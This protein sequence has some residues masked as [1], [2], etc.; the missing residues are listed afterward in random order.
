VINRKGYDGAKADIWACGVILYV[1]LAGYLP[2]QEKT[3]MGMYKKICRAEL[4]WPSW[5]SSD[6][7]KLLRRILHPNPS[8]RISIAE[9]MENPW[10]RTGLDARLFNGNI[11]PV[12]GVVSANMDLTLNSLNVTTV[13]EE[14]EAEKL[15]NL[16]AFDIISLSRGFDLSGIFEENSSKEESKFTSNNTASTIITKLEDIAKSLRLKLTNKD[17]GLL[18]MEGSKPGRKGVMSVDAEIFQI[19]PLFHLV[20]IK[21]TNG[22]TLE[23]NKVMEQDMRSA[24]KGMS[25][26]GKVSNPT[27]ESTTLDLVN[28]QVQQ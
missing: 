18:K 22:D 8:A 10:F 23:Y 19:T 17:G 4:K 9:I 6:V 26:P 3:L 15:T 21:K 1:L 7:R 14:Q 11:N 28:K 24:L 16:N 27:A 5:F 20:E 2:F 12:E 25:G 13:E